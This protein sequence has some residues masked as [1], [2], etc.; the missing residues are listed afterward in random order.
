MLAR[1]A[2]EAVAQAA[3]FGFPVVAKLASRQVPH[4]SDMGGVRLNLS[5]AQ[6]VREAFEDILTHAGASLVADGVL[7][8][9][10]IPG[11]I[12]T[13][14]G[15]AHDPLFGSLVGFG[16]GGTEVEVFGD[17]RFR[18]APLTD[19][20]ADELLHEIRGLRLLQG[21]RGRPPADFNAL[22]DVVLRVSRLAETLPEIVE[23]DLN[24]VIA[25]SPGKGCRIVD[26]RIRVSAAP[27]R[28]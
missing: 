4:K 10:M 17:V 20:D 19:R 23:L 3:V 28:A 1:T 14:V 27:P 25:L 18:V 22:R 2:D 12:E 6:E 11:G 5:S 24:P 13:I 8:Q 7:I 15:V 9:P 26:A 16:I 21:F